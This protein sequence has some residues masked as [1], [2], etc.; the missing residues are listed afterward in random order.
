MSGLLQAALAPAV[1]CAIYIF[2]RDKYEKEP[3]RL[4][5]LGL[6]Y[7]AYS[8][9]II[10]AVGGVVD[11]YIIFDFAN[12]ENLYTAFITSSGIEEGT[13]YMILYFLVWRNKNFNERFDGIVYATYV[14]LGFAAVENIIYVLNPELGGYNTALSRAIFSVPGHCLFGVVMGYYFALAKFEVINKNRRLAQAFLVPWF[15]HGVYNTILLMG[16]TNYMILLIP[17]VIFLWVSGF[18]KMKY[19]IDN[20][21]FK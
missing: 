5:L 12:W 9:S 6:L 11:K 3:I 13:K 4:L 1:I 19:H 8:T 14:S 21:P 7:G 15:F 16:L 20:S 10:L 17:F 18:N 2:I